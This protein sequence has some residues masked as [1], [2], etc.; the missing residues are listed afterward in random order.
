MSLDELKIA[1]IIAKRN[2][3]AAKQLSDVAFIKASNKVIALERKISAEQRRLDNQ[4]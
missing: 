4:R 2:Y 1:L 3:N